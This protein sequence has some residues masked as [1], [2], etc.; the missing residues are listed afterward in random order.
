VRTRALA[1]IASHR[2]A[3][4]ETHLHS[5]PGEIDPQRRLGEFGRNLFRG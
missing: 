4:R 1:R 2:I 3:S 5:I